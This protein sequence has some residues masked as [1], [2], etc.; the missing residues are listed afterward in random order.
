V[1]LHLDLPAGIHLDFGLWD[2]LLIICVAL[3]S[4]VLAYLPSPRLKAFVLMLPIPFTLA[5]LMLGKGVTVSTV[6]GSLTLIIF[7]TSVR[8][9]YNNF[10]WHIVPALTVSVI[11]YCI[12]GVLIA[13]F[14]PEVE[15]L[16]WVA[17]AFV[18]IVGVVGGVL[19]PHRDE[20]HHRTPL[21]I[22]TKA[23]IILGVVIA[24]VCAKKLLEG[25]TQTFPMVGLI[26]NYEGR[27]CLWTI[28]RAIVRSICAFMPMFMVIRLLTP[29]IGL[30]GAL[31]CGWG[32]YLPALALVVWLDRRDA[33]RHGKKPETAE[34]AV[35]ESLGV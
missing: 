8:V 3:M 30:P 27:H 7:T 28:N 21:P 13:R 35:G 15:W 26:G 20:P 18:S 12:I 31:A 6:F 9:L 2:Y 19:M 25:F 14:V 10:R 1:E 16:F 5:T 33:K 17:L 34:T 29:K 23:P 24:L 32:V 22:Y 4:L 11:G